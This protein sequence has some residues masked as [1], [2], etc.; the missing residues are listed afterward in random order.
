M[1]KI[2]K[3]FSAILALAIS[4]ICFTFVSKP[5]VASANNSSYD[6]FKLVT[7]VIFTN[8]T[9]KTNRLAGSE[10]EG[11]TKD[12][13]F[14][15]LS[16]ETQLKKRDDGRV[17]E[18]IQEFTFE[19]YF[20]G[21][22]E[23]SQ[24]I[25]FGLD[26]SGTNK[27]VVLG[28]HYD[29][30]AYKEDSYMTVDDIVAS[31]GI[32]ASAGSVALLLAIAR[33]IHTWNLN[34]DV[35]IVFFG[36]GESNL[37]GSKYYTQ[38]LTEKE[39]NNIVAMINFDGVAFGKN[40]YFYVDEVETKFEKFVNKVSTKNNLSI[41]QVNT[42]N[43]NKVVGVQD[44]LG[45][46][47]THIALASNHVYFKKLGIN[48]INFFAGDYSNG[49]VMGRSEFEG[50]DLIRYTENDSLEYIKTHYG[51]EVVTENL[52]KVYNMVYSTLT[53]TGFIG[54]AGESNQ[55]SWFY[56]LFANSHLALYLTAVAFVVF[57]VV[58]MFVYYKLT[59]KAYYSNV[60]L[61][62]LS[63][64]MKISEQIDGQ[65]TDANVPKAVSQLIAND[66]KKDK[67]I[68]RS[69]KDKKDEDENN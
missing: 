9:S 41:K 3:A 29:S 66:I 44:E 48:T 26:K 2:F 28:T 42:I 31:E 20:S 19:S 40:Q 57:V 22:Y 7:D 52:F 18:G 38:G 4:V 37:A 68:K 34:F 6:S 50:K 56:L 64:V 45:L 24:N 8:I 69:R 39:Q 5:Q 27:K 12:Y 49:I 32:N 21:K 16:T 15:Y 54:A 55:S 61:E 43:L 47:Y 25:V 30:V 35:E 36:A 59:I 67:T 53:D 14:N 33:D 60:E 58:A 23:K 13:I 65:G 51:A 17:K 11:L 62:F 63:S 10:E 1:K 46:G